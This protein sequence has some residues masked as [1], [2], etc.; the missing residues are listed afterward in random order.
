[1][2]KK[3]I[4]NGPD[5]LQNNWK[6]KPSPKQKCE[7]RN[8]DSETFMVWAGIT[9]R[10]KSPVCF[11]TTKMNLEYHIKLLNEVLIDFGE[12]FIGN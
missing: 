10:K 6:N 12:E 4:L 1:M 7:R 9:Y 11:V 5:V 8:F 3:F 2:N